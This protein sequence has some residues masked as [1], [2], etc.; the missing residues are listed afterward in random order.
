MKL[1]SNI[2]GWEYVWEEFAEE[3]GGKVVKDGQGDEGNIVALHIP[4]ANTDTVISIANAAAGTSMAFSYEPSNDFTMRIFADSPIHKL[5][6]VFGLQD[7]KIGDREFDSK[8][9]IQ[10]NHPNIVEQLVASDELRKAIILENVAELRT[11]SPSVGFDKRWYVPPTHNVLLCQQHV[12]LDKFDQLD[13]I[14]KILTQ[15][16]SA[17]QDCGLIGL[18]RAHAHAQVSPDAGD[19]R[20]ASGRLRSPLLDR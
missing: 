15:L 14:Y 20:T 8:Y 7:L 10:S 1:H 17:L 12:F 16:L 9:V 19:A 5:E 13:C 18:G 11:V 4:L 2:Y 3:K 6:K